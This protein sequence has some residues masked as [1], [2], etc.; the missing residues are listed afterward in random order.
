MAEFDTSMYAN[1]RPPAPVS[2]S[3]IANPIEMAT[4]T[5]KLGEL[6][7]Q[8]RQ[9]QQEMQD[10]QTMREAFQNNVDPQ[11]GQVNR[12]GVIAY[13]AT[14]APM[15][16][17]QLQNQ[18]IQNDAAQAEQKQKM[19]E[20][21]MNNYGA[22]ARILGA[23]K[24]Q[25]EWG[26]ALTTLT[27]MGLPTQMAPAE[28]SREAADGLAHM[29]NNAFLDSKDRLA[30]HNAEMDQRFKAA[31]LGVKNKEL[32]LKLAEFGQ[33][34]LKDLKEDLNPYKA[35]GGNLARY[36]QKLGAA[37]SVLQ[38]SKQF[39][40][41]NMPKPQQVEFATAVASL[42][43]GGSPQ[44]QQQIEEMVPKSA[45][46][47][48]NAMAS[49]I[50]GLPKGA[51]Q[52]AFMKLLNDTALRE[53]ALADAQKK[54]AQVSLL[55]SHANVARMNPQAFWQT[56]GNFGINQEDVQVDPKTGAF[57]W[58][59]GKS[60]KWE[61]RDAQNTGVEQ[62]GGDSGGGLIPS[63]QAGGGK[64]SFN[65]EDLQMFKLAKERYAKDP[66]DR[67]AQRT[68]SILQQRGLK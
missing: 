64:N 29:A 2:P 50:I 53:G 25:K 26:Q 7:L 9:M 4:S 10:K 56:A 12:A 38:L 61:P 17:M 20:T 27:Q 35:R 52:Q 15:A 60:Y 40:D 48:A 28:F 54:D 24:N 3:A 11:T 6:M 13:A 46:G 57:K 22:A 32:D 47:D 59:P 43:S 39:P 51:E 1:V 18:W 55:G 58:K 5:V 23:A 8:S 68:L 19:L 31:E 41:L 36:E 44:S 63:A 14:K 16:A 65:A 33:G 62:D 67:E 49:Y 45:R 21:Q 66:S 34:Q 30:A 37:E 42:I